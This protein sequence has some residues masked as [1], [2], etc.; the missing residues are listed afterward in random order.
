MKT[1]DSKNRMGDRRLG[2]R[3]LYCSPSCRLSNALLCKRLIHGNK[4][5]AYYRFI[6]N[7][8]ALTL[9]VNVRLN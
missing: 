6:N 2:K 9:C 7:E 4:Q 8:K 5:I 3:G 1:I